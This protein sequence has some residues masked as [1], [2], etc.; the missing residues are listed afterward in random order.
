MNN[1][2]N[3]IGDVHGKVDEYKDIISN[4]DY[5]VQI[6]DMAFDYSDIKIDDHH[7]ILLGNHDN[8]DF[9]CPHEV[10]GLVRVSSYL[11]HS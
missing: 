6:G 1:T 10:L 2:I 4:L 7:K 11:N 9:L 8:Y 5:S 3:I